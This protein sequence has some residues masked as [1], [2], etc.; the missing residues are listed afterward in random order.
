MAEKDVAE[1]DE[2]KNPNDSHT[3]RKNARAELKQAS[4]TQVLDLGD[5]FKTDAAFIKEGATRLTE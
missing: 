1:K 4:V 5:K 3:D 2:L